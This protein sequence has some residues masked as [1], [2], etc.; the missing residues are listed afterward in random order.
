MS[1]MIYYGLFVCVKNKVYEWD[2]D[3]IESVLFS[4]VEVV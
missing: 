4:L 1:G 3:D 2:V